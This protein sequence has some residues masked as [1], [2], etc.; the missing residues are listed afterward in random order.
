VPGGQW[1]SRQR[2]GKA[3]AQIEGGVV[4]RLLGGVGPKVQGVA[5]AAALK[6]VEILLIE[7]GREAAA[8]AT[9]RAVQRARAALLAAAAGGGLE[10]EQFQDGRHGDGGANGGEVDGWTRR[11]GGLTLRLLVLSLTQFFATFT[12]LGQFAVAVVG[13]FL[14]AAVEFVL[15]RN[16]ADGGMQADGVVMDDVVGDDA[17]GIAERQGHENADALALDGF[18]PAFDFAVGLRI[19][20]RSLDMGHAGDADEFLEVL[21]DELGSVVADDAGLGVGVGFVGALDDG[22]HVRLLHFLADFP[23]NDEAAATVEDRTQK[24]KGAGDVEVTDINMPVFVG[25]Q[26]LDEAGAFLGDVGRWPGQESGGLEDAVDAGRATSDLVGIEHHEGQ[27]PVAFQGMFAGEE[28]DFVFFIVGK[29][30]V[31]RHPGVVLVDLAEAQLPVVELA[32]TDADPGQEMG[33]GDV[34]FIAPGD[35]EIDDGVAR[36][37]G[38]PAAGQLSPRFFLAVH[39]LP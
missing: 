33:D 9:G 18:V 20:G 12:R 6:A 22:F 15:G 10:A 31:A 2:D 7:V 11:V 34:G 16:V 38:Y 28:A 36:V 24:V 26:G 5:T 25:I 17:A 3:L 8:G 37:V 30:V 21:G 19:I 23:V 1:Q 14:G 35:G 32:G 27:A 4:G 29:P 13:D 39:A